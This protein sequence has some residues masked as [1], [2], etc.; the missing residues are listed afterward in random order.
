MFNFVTKKPYSGS[1]V[2]TLISAAAQFGFSQPYWMT[3]N[4]ARTKGRSVIAGSKG[5]KI[6][7]IVEVEEFNEITK[8]VEK[9]QKPKYFVVFNIEQTQEN[10]EKVKE[11]A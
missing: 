3:F 7:R 4:Q 1:N 8:R 2:D 5:V 9:V 10:A 11:A 6:C